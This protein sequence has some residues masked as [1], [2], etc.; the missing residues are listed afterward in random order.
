MKIV[1]LAAAMAAFLC[2]C[3]T[4]ET[5]YSD[6]KT[7]QGKVVDLVFMPANHGSS[8]DP[9]MSMSGNITL[10]FTSV[11]LPEKHAV[12]FQCQHGRFVVESEKAKE[13]YQRLSRDQAVTISY[14][15]VFN[16]T[17]D[18]TNIIAPKSFVKFDF[19]DAR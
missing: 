15:E 4:H 16:L 12:V 9:G 19:I 11:T 2:G 13:L 14:R 10:T 1:L 8:I 5:E 6:V 17:R 3:E 18:G 7:E